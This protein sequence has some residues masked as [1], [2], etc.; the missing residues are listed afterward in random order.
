MVQLRWQRVAEALLSFLPRKPKVEPSPEKRPPASGELALG[1]AYMPMPGLRLTILE[2][3]A[4]NSSNGAQTGGGVRLV[5]RVRAENLS[6]KP[7]EFDNSFG[8][9]DGQGRAHTR[10]WVDPAKAP[11][12]MPGIATI[13]PGES[14]EG[15]VFIVISGSSTPPFYPAYLV[16]LGGCANCPQSTDL[17]PTAIWQ[18]FGIGT[19]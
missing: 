4:E 3:R 16:L 1:Q 2:T 13:A 18:P 11:A 14:L 15:D 10:T 5:L 12:V 7:L 9:I 6:D 19:T 17:V 8:I